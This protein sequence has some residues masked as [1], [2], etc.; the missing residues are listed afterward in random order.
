MD[1]VTASNNSNNHHGST[2]KFF[3]HTLEHLTTSNIITPYTRD[4]LIDMINSDAKRDFAKVWKHV[5]YIMA[6]HDAF[7]TAANNSQVGPVGAPSGN[8][9]ENGSGGKQAKKR[10]K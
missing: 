9:N 3:I 8:G 1:A 7:A 4:M 10:A 5:L 2:K 6:L